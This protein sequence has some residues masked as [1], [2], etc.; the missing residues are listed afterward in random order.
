MA[1]A[2]ATAEGDF[3]RTPLAHLLV[4]SLDKRLTGVLFLTEPGGVEHVVRLQRGVPVK[5]R[6][7]Y[8]YALLGEML[9]DAGAIDRETLEAALATKGLLGDML[10]LAGRVD[11]D[12]L[13]RVCKEQFLRRLV[14]LY[15]LPPGT[16]Y[17]YFDGHSELA[18]WGGEP[19]KIDPVS[20][21]WAGIRVNGEASALMEAS[22]AKLGEAPLRLHAQ[23]TV[24]RFG[25]DENEAPL[26]ECLEAQP[27]TLAQ[28]AELEVVDLALLRRFAY[29]LLITRQL[30][31]GSGTVPLGAV[32]HTP[33]P[34]AAPSAAGTAAVAKMVLKSTAYRM[35][36]AAPDMPG[37]GGERVSVVPR[38]S[39][40]SRGGDN[41]PP[42]TRMDPPSS[43][44]ADPPSSP[45]LEVPP[46]TRGE[47]TPSSRSES[48]TVLRG[49]APP[50]PPS[51]REA[52]P[53]PRVEPPPAPP[54]RPEAPPSAR[55][56]PPPRPA[57]PPAPVEEAEALELPEDPEDDLDGG[58]VTM[59]R[60]PPPSSRS[61]ALSPSSRVQPAPR[62][63]SNE[64]AAPAAGPPPSGGAPSPSR[65]PGGPAR[66][67]RPPLAEVDDDIAGLP[68]RELFQLALARLSS[69][70][71][72]AALVACDLAKCASPEEPDFIVLSV[73][74]RAQMAGAD[75]KVL[76]VELDEVVTARERNVNAR[77]Y[78]ALIRKR[79][80][81]REAAVADLK[82]VLELT[83]QHVEAKRELGNLEGSLSDGARPSLFGK[84]FKR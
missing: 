46:S 62:P 67:S 2:S 8:E 18:E 31:L 72:T 74:I 65:P 51:R 63:P 29:A 81:E 64:P 77:Y 19:A 55:A 66:P 43:S 16:V 22:L 15:G 47:T 7:G 5:V 27:T 84:L 49:E 57:P 40:D 13:E 41:G 10:L 4:Y 1:D 52:P 69:R 44:R 53:S 50:A 9:V 45:S 26:L 76:C 21:I 39:R 6:P 71:L 48:Q 75:L 54:S 68:P 58:D 38:R 32:D 60:E 56:E 36:A 33:A 79:M 17:R 83:P 24:A 70:D 82:R 37:D 23:Q 30:D 14:M 35:G 80:G 59:F 20:L 78:R 28:L 61:E 3:G 42:S 34:K 11:Q 12:V 25:L 73:W